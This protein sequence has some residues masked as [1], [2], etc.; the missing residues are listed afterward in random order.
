MV[1]EGALTVAGAGR[2]TRY[3]NR[4]RAISVTLS[5]RDLDEASAWEDLDTPESLVRS[6]SA[7]A[8]STMTY[9]FTE[10]VNNVVDHSGASEVSLEI[11][12]HASTIILE[13]I[14]R[15][16]GIFEH[17]RRRLGL[18]NEIEALQELS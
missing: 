2:S 18:A 1:E 15:G 8:R 13:V 5:T 7:P 17:I 14:D 11:R 10:L 3:R 9:A 16:I 4:D 6:L 12:Q